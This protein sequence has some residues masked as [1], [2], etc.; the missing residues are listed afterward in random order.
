MLAPRFLTLN[1]ADKVLT[2]A[3]L[4][5]GVALFVHFIISLNRAMQMPTEDED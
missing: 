4:A 1:L 3:S 2:I 5:A